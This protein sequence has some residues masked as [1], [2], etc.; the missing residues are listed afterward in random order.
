MLVN[1]AFSFIY[2]I[3]RANDPCC[4]IYLAYVLSCSL[5]AI[6]YVQVRSKVNFLW[7]FSNERRDIYLPYFATI[8]YIFEN[9]KYTSICV[10]IRR[11]PPFTHGR[12]SLSLCLSSLLNTN[13]LPTHLNKEKKRYLFLH[14]Y[15]SL[16]CT[17]FSPTHPSPL[18]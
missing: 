10:H 1:S 11:T 16:L 13:F 6:M 9:P 18:L 17:T 3:G 14:I 8:I 5:Y 4:S 7:H 12:R 2:C 15:P